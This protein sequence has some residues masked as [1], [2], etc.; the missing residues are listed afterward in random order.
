MS[1][2]HKRLVVALGGN[3]ISAPGKVGTICRDHC[4]DNG[5]I[6]RAC[7]DT[8]VFAPP[9][10]IDRPEIEQWMVMLRKALDLTLADIRR[11]MQ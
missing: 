5:L 6:M 10:I 9:L 1:D 2:A 3:A 8:M 7:W 11:E 4:I